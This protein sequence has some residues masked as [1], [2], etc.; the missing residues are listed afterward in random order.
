MKVFLRSVF[1][2]L[3]LRALSGVSLILWSALSKLIS[4]RGP[5][6]AHLAVTPRVRIAGQ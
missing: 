4:I 2:F 3:I 6:K 1:V 5:L